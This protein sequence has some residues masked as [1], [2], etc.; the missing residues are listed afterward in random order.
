MGLGTDREAWPE[1]CTSS[2]A[3]DENGNLLYFHTKPLP[4]GRLTIGLY[5]DS[6][7]SVDYQGSITIESVLSTYYNNADDDGHSNCEKHEDED[8]DRY[9]ASTYDLANYLDMWH[10][11]FDVYHYCQPCKAYNLGYIP[12]EDFTDDAREYDGDDAYN[13]NEGHFS[14]YDDA[15]Y[16][17]VNQCMKFATKTFML[18]ASFNDVMLAA[19]QGTIRN[20]D[21]AGTTYGS[22]RSTFSRAAAA[23]VFFLIFSILICCGGGYLLHRAVRN[24]ERNSS[25]VEPLVPGGGVAA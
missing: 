8:D 6:R 7:C 15:D 2:Y 21:V 14:C 11:T 9:C 22:M 25:F 20:V 13:P 17:N 3:Q 4:E 12:G 23:E 24:A 19:Q 5:T 10:D 1:K 18:T 16:L